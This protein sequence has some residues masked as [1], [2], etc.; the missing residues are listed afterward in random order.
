MGASDMLHLGWFTNYLPPSWNRTWSG[1]AADTWASGDFHINLAR[2]LEEGRL[3]YLLLEDSSYVSNSYAGDFELELRQMSRAPKHDPMPLVAAMGRETQ[4]LGLIATG[5]TTYYPPFLLARLISTLD[6]LTKGRAGWNIVTGGPNQALA[7]FG[8]DSREELRDSAAAHDLRYE[9][10]DEFADLVIKLWESWDADAVITDRANDRYIESSKVRTVDHR[11]A[12]FS[13]R[14]PLNTIPSPQYRPTICQAGGSPRG[15]A[16]AAKY[17]DTIVALPKGIAHMKKYVEDVRAQL[18]IAGRDPDSCKV[19]FLVSPTLGDDDA[20]ARR[21]REDDR[22]REDERVRQRLSLMSGGEEDWSKY[23]LDERLPDLSGTG[24]SSSNTFLRVNAGKTFRQALADD[25]TE[26]V[27]LVGSPSTVAEQMASVADETGGD[28]FLFYSGSGQLTMRY[29][30]E[31]IDGL[32]P[33]LQRAGRAR[34]E[35]SAPTLKGHLQEF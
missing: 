12:H 35:Y 29:V 24:Q 3:D 31:V 17:A 26:A 6:H 20:D 21:R 10:A 15:I 22:S 18:E 13:S 8:L 19:M 32:V 1:R 25:T 30:D 5:N 33:E 28:G 2:K 23:P 7:N 9:I 27:E 14:G 34:L 16:F 4:H 11:G